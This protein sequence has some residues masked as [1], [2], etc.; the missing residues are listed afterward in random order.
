[1]E[2]AEMIVLEVAREHQVRVEDMMRPERNTPAAI[3]REAAWKR[4]RMETA[5]SYPQIGAMFGVNHSSVYCCV[6][7]PTERKM[8]VLTKSRADTARELWSTH[9]PEEIAGVLGLTAHGVRGIAKRHKLG[10]ACRADPR[11]KK[12]HRPFTPRCAEIY[13]SM[14][15]LL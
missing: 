8:S 4:L 2:K 7:R 13:H 11:E 10:P 14:G 3:A 1:M 12:N 5:L 6:N 15:L 9:T